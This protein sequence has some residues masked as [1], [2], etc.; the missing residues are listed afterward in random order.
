VVVF[1][2]IWKSSDVASAPRMCLPL[3]VVPPNTREISD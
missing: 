3:N 2:P 1:A